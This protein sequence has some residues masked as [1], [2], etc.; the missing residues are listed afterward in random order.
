[1]FYL[2]RAEE[3]AG[4]ANELDDFTLKCR[5]HGRDVK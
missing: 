4:K 2:C 5:Y 1:M 3:G